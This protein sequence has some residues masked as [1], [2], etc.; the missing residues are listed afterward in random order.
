MEDACI[1]MVLEY[2]EID[3]AGMLFA[4]RKEMQSSN[5][6]DLDE[7]WLR[8]YWQV[9]ICHVVLLRHRSTLP[10]RL[11]SFCLFLKHIF[12][13]LQ[14]SELMYGFTYDSVNPSQES[15]G[16]RNDNAAGFLGHFALLP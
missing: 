10:R 12:D 15:R 2:G 8:F 9:L 14:F 5:E 6:T 1:Y 4:K 7:N 16:N 3:L 11:E 13:C